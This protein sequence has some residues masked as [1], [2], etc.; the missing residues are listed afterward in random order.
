MG[1]AMAG[2]SISGHAGTG[3]DLKRTRRQK[4]D[5][6]NGADRLPPHSP[7]M[8]RGVLGC[9]LIDPNKCLPEV[10]TLKKS[11]FY[12]LRNQEIFSALVKMHSAGNAIDI[13]TLQQNLKD[14]GL[15]EQ[16]GGIPYLSQLQDAVPSAANLSYYL[17]IVREKFDLRKIISTCTDVVGRVYDY[18]GPIDD[19]KFSVQSDL[20]D[21]FGDTATPRAFQRPKEKTRIRFKRKTGEPVKAR[22]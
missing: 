3:P 13:I 12:D 5:A 18:N 1:A 2:E 4:P 22:L 15:L 19:L 9:V 14:A 6:R 20:A 10:L 11:A 21:V 8:E 16:I 17:D 7:E